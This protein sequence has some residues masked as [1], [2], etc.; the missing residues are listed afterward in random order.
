MSTTIPSTSKPSFS[1]TLTRHKSQPTSN[2]KNALPTGAP[3]HPAPFC[4]PPTNHHDCHDY[5][6]TSCYKYA[7]SHCH[8]GISRKVTDR[9]LYPGVAVRGGHDKSRKV[10]DNHI[11]SATASDEELL[12]ILLEEYKN[13]EISKK[14]LHDA[15]EQHKTL[16]QTV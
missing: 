11:W 15:L 12:G 10:L 3:H 5:I 13:G 9:C 8:D 2:P 6:Q 4:S 1:P 14:D 7:A 16:V